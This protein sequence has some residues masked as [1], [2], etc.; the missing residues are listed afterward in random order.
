VTSVR[1]VS[2]KRSAKQ[3]AGGHRGGILTCG[4][5]ERVSQSLISAFTAGRPD[6]HRPGQTQHD[7]RCGLRTR[8]PDARSRTEL[9]GATPYSDAAEDVEI[10]L[11]HEWPCYAHQ[12]PANTYLTRPRRAQRA[13][14]AVACPLRQTAAGRRRG[15]QRAPGGSRPTSRSR[16]GMVTSRPERRLHVQRNARMHLRFAVG[17]DTMGYIDNGQ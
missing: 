10:L 8:L 17:R 14:H 1:T 3:F 4:C 15:V 12:L 6:R 2:T 5:R 9:A 11:R 13:E 16:G 7:R